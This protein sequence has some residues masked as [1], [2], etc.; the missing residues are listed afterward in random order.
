MFGSRLVCNVP[1]ERTLVDK[2]AGNTPGLSFLLPCI[3]I[4]KNST[5]RDNSVRFKWKKK[6]NTELKFF[7]LL[8]LYNLYIKCKPWEILDS[9]YIIHLN[10]YNSQHALYKE[11]ISNLYPNLF[12]CLA[13][14]GGMFKLQVPL[15][16]PVSLTC[17]C[18]YCQCLCLIEKKPS[19]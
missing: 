19:Q 1:K 11:R 17:I 12:Y 18:H 10:Q 8:G 3:Q 15:E 9:S 2:T 6:I 4:Q 5:K 13:P 7:H 14:S 16:E